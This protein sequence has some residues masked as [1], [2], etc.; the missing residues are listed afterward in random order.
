MWI[1]F[2]LTTKEETYYKCKIPKWMNIFFFNKAKNGTVPLLSL[3]VT[4]GLYTTVPI[5]LAVN[6]FNPTVD[7][8]VLTFYYLFL[9]W[10]LIATPFMIV[11]EGVASSKKKKRIKEEEEARIKMKRDNWIAN[12]VKKKKK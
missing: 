8:F 10:V 2:S 11:L 5:L 6:Y 9:P 4:I 1:F 12:N 7:L 3:A